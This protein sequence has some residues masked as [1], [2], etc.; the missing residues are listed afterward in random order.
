MRFTAKLFA[1]QPIIK[2][3]GEW[4]EDLLLC[5]IY[6]ARTQVSKKGRTPIL[7][8]LANMAPFTEVALSHFSSE[9]YIIFVIITTKIEEK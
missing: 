8:P 2:V 5:N 7:T 4:W 3:Q 6:Q 9:F 1:K